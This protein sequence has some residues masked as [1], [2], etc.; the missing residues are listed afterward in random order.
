MAT[1]TA[2][3]T[4]EIVE[5]STSEKIAALYELQTLD[6]RIDQINFIKGSLPLEISDMQDEI[7]GIEAKISGFLT[8]SDTL[9]TDVK[10]KKGEIEAAKIAIAKYEEQQKEVRN[11][12]EFE[13]IGKEIEFQQLE[14]ELC[15]KRI[16]EFTADSKVK[17]ALANET[18][19]ILEDRKK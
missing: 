12:R 18:K 3:Q 6:S 5:L 7:A 15:E 14:I 10:T 11:N 19:D 16:K 9:L 2:K 4:N 8:E 17:K 13:S 1:K